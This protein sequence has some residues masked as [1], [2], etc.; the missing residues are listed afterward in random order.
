[1]I[2]RSAIA[3]INEAVL[4]KAGLPHYRFFDA[5]AALPW[6]EGIYLYGS[7]ARGDYDR[8][9]DI[10]LAIKTEGGER[11]RW[12]IHQLAEAADTL[13]KVDCVLLNE[14]LT[15][16]FRKAIERDKVTLFERE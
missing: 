11:E 16:L 1:M 15:D 3:G 8:L 4:Q 9:S 6:V 5:L 13:H 14:P 2:E 7:R 10:D 12:I